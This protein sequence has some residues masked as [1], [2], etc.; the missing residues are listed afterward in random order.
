VLGIA[1]MIPL[2]VLFGRCTVN[3][4]GA[5]ILS[6]QVHGVSEL[7]DRLTSFKHRAWRYEAGIEAVL[8]STVPSVPVRPPRRASPNQVVVHL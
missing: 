1:D 2:S 5:V 8:V 4:V 7:A 6:D 3:S